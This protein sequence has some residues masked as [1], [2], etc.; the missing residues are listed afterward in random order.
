MRKQIRPWNKKMM[1]DGLYC[2]TLIT[3]WLCFWSLEGFFYV[4]FSGSNLSA[5]AT[6]N[7]S[8]HSIS[9]INRKPVKKVSVYV[10]LLLTMKS[11]VEYLLNRKYIT[12]NCKGHRAFAVFL[13]GIFHL[14]TYTISVVKFHRQWYNFLI[15]KIWDRKSFWLS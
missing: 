1:F 5:H 14:T 10:T 13:S 12:Y 8:I 3:L 15:K 11:E 9:G 4:F 7:L 6:Q 2:C